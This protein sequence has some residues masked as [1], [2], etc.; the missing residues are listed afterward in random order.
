MLRHRSPVRQSDPVLYRDQ[1]FPQ[2]HRHLARVCL[3]VS[4]VERQL[5]L[6]LRVLDDDAVL[7][8]KVSRIPSWAKGVVFGL[9]GRSEA[10]HS[11]SHLARYLQGMNEVIEA[12]FQEGEFLQARSIEHLISLA[13]LGLMLERM[14]HTTDSQSLNMIYTYKRFLDPSSGSSTR[15]SREATN[16]AHFPEDQSEAEED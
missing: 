6:E 16:I 8:K 13:V 12:N 2:V 10:G 15:I 7:K 4:I 5:D 14:G 1:E 11:L 3:R 9:Q